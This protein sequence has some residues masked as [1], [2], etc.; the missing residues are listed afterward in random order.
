MGKL[1]KLLSPW[2]LI[3]SNTCQTKPFLPWT[4]L[5]C[6]FFK[7]KYQ[8]TRVTIPSPTHQAYLE[9][10]KNTIAYKS[11]YSS[12]IT[13]RPI[14]TMYTCATPQVAYPEK[15]LQYYSTSP[16]QPKPFFFGQILFATKRKYKGNNP[17]LPPLH[18]IISRKPGTVLH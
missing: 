1:I 16:F 14:C 6:N 5:I 12:W 17:L 13:F 11:Y 4:N 10:A 9:E 2:A 8:R 3:F 7:G 18:Q 15:L